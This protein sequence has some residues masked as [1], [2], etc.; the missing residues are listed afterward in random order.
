MREEMKTIKEFMKKHEEKEVY[1]EKVLLDDVHP[2]SPFIYGPQHKEP[3]VESTLI[4]D[5][6]MTNPLDQPH[7]EPPCEPSLGSFSMSQVDLKVNQ[8]S[9]EETTILIPQNNNL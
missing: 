5:V 2:P 9:T 7:F 1:E 6:H 8:P 3:K 4:E